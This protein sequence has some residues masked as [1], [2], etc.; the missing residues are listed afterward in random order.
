MQK[1]VAFSEHNPLE[2]DKVKNESIELVEPRQKRFFFAWKISPFP[3][4]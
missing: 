2:M 3:L 1:D 4:E